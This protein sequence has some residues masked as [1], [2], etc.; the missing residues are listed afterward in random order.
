MGRHS[1]HVEKVAH[2]NR[3]PAACSIG[4]HGLDPE[5][6]QTAP[7][8]DRP[9]ALMFGHARDIVD[10]AGGSTRDIVEMTV[11]MKGRSQRHLIDPHWEAM[12]PDPQDRPARPALK[13][14]LDGD[15]LVQCDFIAV[16]PG[17]I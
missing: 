13:S 12:F 1:I 2:R 9:C 4:N 15:R 5:T 8:M 10:A 17:S 16:L 6:R 7:G 11:W 14:D 3:V